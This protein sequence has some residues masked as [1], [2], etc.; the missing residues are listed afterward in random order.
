[1]FLTK[2]SK[3]DTNFQ[4]SL[5]SNTKLSTKTQQKTGVI[6]LPILTENN[7]TLSI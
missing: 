1:M 3:V 7:E 5:L 2:K 4:S 6:S